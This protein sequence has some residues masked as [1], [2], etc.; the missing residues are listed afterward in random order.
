MTTM[1]AARHAAATRLIRSYT[2]SPSGAEKA[3]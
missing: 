2:A 3:R 1:A